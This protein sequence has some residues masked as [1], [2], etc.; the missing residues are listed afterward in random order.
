MHARGWLL[1]ALLLCGHAVAEEASIMIAAP[2]ASGPVE[3][4]LSG[5]RN[6]DYEAE[7]AAFKDAQSRPGTPPKP[8]AYFSENQSIDE[9]IAEQLPRLNGRI[10][11]RAGLLDN[12]SAAALRQTLDEHERQTGDQI[13]VV[14]LD[15]LRGNSIEEFGYRLGRYWGVGQKGKNNGVLLIVVPNDR[16]VRIEV[17]YGLEDRLTDAQS[18]LIINQLITPK[19]KQEQFAEGIT[20][21][22]AA[23]ID[24]LGGQPVAVV[25]DDPRELWF[26]GFFVAL[27]AIFIT[28]FGYRVSRASRSGGPSE[29]NSSSGSSSSSSSDSG[30]G[31]GSFGGGGASGSW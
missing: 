20:A 19:F 16:R 21:G 3:F 7:L 13:V 18:S 29:G 12:A 6:P 26:N 28:L 4:D 14:T 1:A 8:A 11:D 31:G 2:A 24:V 30:G 23:M 25:G 5:H 27:A 17:G 22:V 15:S 10:V 9:L